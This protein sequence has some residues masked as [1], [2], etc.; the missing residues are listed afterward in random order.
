LHQAHEV[1]TLFD[2]PRHF[3]F[4]ESGPVPQADRPLGDFGADLDR[5]LLATAAGMGLLFHT[6]ARM[7]PPLARQ[8]FT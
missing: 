7:S 2:L 1:I 6:I 3:F 8:R 5:D 4:I